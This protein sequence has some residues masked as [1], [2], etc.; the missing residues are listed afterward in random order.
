VLAT[1]PPPPLTQETLLKLN[2]RLGGPLWWSGPLERSKISVPYQDSNPGSS[3]LQ[4]S[5]YTVH[6]ILALHVPCVQNIMYHLVCVKHTAMLL[7]VL[8]M[9]LI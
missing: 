4:L 8:G 7:E 9:F 6:T 5:H 3:S 1:A 2:Q